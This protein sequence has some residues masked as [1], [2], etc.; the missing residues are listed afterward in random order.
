MLL[1]QV[2]YVLQV[3]QIH[4]QQL[5]LKDISY[6]QQ[7]HVVHVLQC[8]ILH[9]HLHL[10]VIILFGHVLEQQVVQ[11][12]I[13]YKMDILVKKVMYLMHLQV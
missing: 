8:Q 6:L 5:V 12:V 1:V 10:V 2:G 9:L 4:K 7:L 3:Q 11:L 13:I